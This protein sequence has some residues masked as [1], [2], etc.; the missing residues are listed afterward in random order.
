M[1]K[2]INLFQQH[3]LPREI[4][5]KDKYFIVE[6]YFMYGKKQIGWIEKEWNKRKFEK[7][8]GEKVI[9]FTEYK[10]KSEYEYFKNKPL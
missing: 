8:S 7:E 9:R 3:K 2:K 1:D 10:T 6:V 5:D 4:D